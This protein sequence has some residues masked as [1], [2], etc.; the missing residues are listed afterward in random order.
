MENNNLK[1]LCNQIVDCIKSK[2]LVNLEALDVRRPG[3][4]RVC[5]CV[6]VC[7]RVWSL[8]WARTAARQHE[9]DRCAARC[10]HA[11]A[12]P[13]PRRPA[14]PPAVPR[15]LTGASRRLHEIRRGAAA[16]HCGARA[17]SVAV[18]RR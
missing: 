4:A 17:C 11:R 12:P 8:V 15:A 14:R 5:V 10:V 16:A 6:R 13:S 2:V 7:V 9:S 18:G 1:Q 3:C